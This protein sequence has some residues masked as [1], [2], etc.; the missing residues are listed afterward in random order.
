[1]IAF[2]GWR[3]RSDR[4]DPLRQKEKVGGAPTFSFKNGR[5]RLLHPRERALFVFGFMELLEDVPN[6]GDFLLV[7]GVEAHDDQ[8]DE[9][10]SRGDD[11]HQVHEPIHDF[12][13]GNHVRFVASRV[14]QPPRKGAT[15]C[16]SELLGHSGCGEHQSGCPASVF[17]FSVV[18]RIGIHRPDQGTEGASGD[19]AENLKQEHG[20]DLVWLE[21][22]E[23]RSADDGDY[24][25]DHEGFLFAQNGSHKG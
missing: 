16:P 10:E 8:E 6:F 4:Y 15:D 21:D 19:G 3:V 18:S 25:I 11:A 17:P 22:V 13:G 2:S 14:E 23:C 9:P 24:P 7:E 5:M 12:R 20:F 1:M